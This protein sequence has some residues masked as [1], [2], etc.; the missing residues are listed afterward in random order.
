MPFRRAAV[1]LFSVL[2]IV[3]CDRDPSG[4]PPPD[5]EFLLLAGDS[6]FWVRNEEARFRVRGSPIQLVRLDGRL[7]E[8]YVADD[9][10]SF[11]GAL[12]VGQRIYRRDL[13]TGDSALVF[14]DTTITSLARWYAHEHPRDRRLAP[15]EEVEEQPHIDVLGEVLTVDQHGPFLSIEYRV[16]GTLEG[17]NELHEVRRGVVDLRDGTTATLEKLFGDSAARRL[18]SEGA[19]RFSV[20]I[21]SVIASGDERAREAIPT[22]PDV[23]FDPASF[24]LAA[25]A[26]E[27]AVEFAATGT[28]PIAGGIVL[29]LEPIR[30][31]IPEW[32][33]EVRETLPVASADSM[34]HAWRHGSVVVEARYDSIGDRARLVVRDTAGGHVWRLASI[35]APAYRLQWLRAGTDSATRQALARAFDEAVLYSEDARTVSGPA[36]LRPR[37][38]YASDAAPLRPLPRRGAPTPVST[39]TR[40]VTFP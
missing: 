6:T 19:R 9:D 30:A 4:P 15:S 5:A 38:R 28:G 24:T 14:D 17:T 29:P 26:G 13:I 39:P 27:P 34:T 35:P 7:V 31:P 20:A 1:T 10:Q 25:L 32:W 12:L 33:A 18:T 21:D 22:L 8:I 16:D 23:T 11:R 3:S 2:G 40:P 37:A 36:V